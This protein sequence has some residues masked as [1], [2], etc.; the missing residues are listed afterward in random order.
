MGDVASLDYVDA[1][2]AYFPLNAC[3]DRCLKRLYKYRNASRIALFLPFRESAL[4]K[5]AKRRA[6]FC[7]LCHGL[8]LGARDPPRVP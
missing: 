6:L 3:R 1:R 8:G 2:H 4:K 7:G 5:R